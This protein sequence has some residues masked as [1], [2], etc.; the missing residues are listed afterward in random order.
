MCSSTFPRNTFGVV[1][2]LGVVLISTVCGFGL[3]V[4]TVGDQRLRLPP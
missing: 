3:A 4:A 2:L 1:Y